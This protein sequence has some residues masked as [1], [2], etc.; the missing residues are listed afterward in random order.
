MQTEDKYNAD[1]YRKLY[2]VK[3]N[4]PSDIK[5]QIQLYTVDKKSNNARVIGSFVYKSGNASDIDIFEDIDRPDK[6]TLISFFVNGVV[7]VANDIDNLKYQ[8]FI[9]VKCGI[10][11]AYYDINHGSCAHDK[12]DMP[13]EFIELMAIY[14]NKGLID[15]DELNIIDQIASK[16]HKNQLDFERIKQILRKRYILRWNIDELNAGYKILHDLDGLYQYPLSLAVQDISNINIEGIYINSFGRYI[17][18]S[19][20]FA[21]AYQSKYGKTIYMNFGELEN[22]DFIAARRENLKT[23]MYTLLYSKLEPNP[24]KALKRMMSF[25]VRFEDVLLVNKAYHIINSEYGKLYALNSQ[26]K[27]LIKVIDAHGKKPL[28]TSA[29]YRQIEYIAWDISNIILINFPIDDIVDKLGTIIGDHHV[30]SM[31]NIHDVLDDCSHMISAYLIKVTY[32]LMYEQGLFPL[33]Q[34]LTPAIKPF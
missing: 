29:L 11:H 4:Y 13:N 31:N 20:F 30:L 6:S 34:R 18:C 9:E 25:G 21:L 10:D 19:N 23:S 26:M 22:T 1:S 7:R 27:T 15:D 3:T 32:K 24:F 14:R 12:Y 33:P 2:N 16:T 8:Y 5:H 28:S 17:D